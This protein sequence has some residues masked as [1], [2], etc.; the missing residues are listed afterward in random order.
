LEGKGVKNLYKI[1]QI[2]K[3]FNLSKQTL[4]YY[5]KISLLS[6]ETIDEE[7]NYRYYDLEQFARLYLI[8]ELK[9][10]NLS[11]NEIKEYCD[12]KNIKEL[13]QLLKRSK[14]DLEHELEELGAKKENI[15]SCLKKIKLAKSISCK[16][17]FEVR[18]IEERYA[19]FIDFNF[20]IRDINKYTD[21]A[22][23][24]YLHSDVIE[25]N[26]FEPGHIVITM[27][28]ENIMAQNFKIY[29]RIGLLLNK[30]NKGRSNI[31][32]ICQDLYAITYHIGSYDK[33]QN[34]YRELYKFIMENKYT[35]KG[36][37]IEISVT[38]IAY[39]DNTDE[40]VTEIQMPVGCIF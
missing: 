32:T 18:K 22:Y 23:V 5:D 30:P 39:T 25:S 38:D 31:K 4:R 28:K 6:P 37:A 9:K 3:F 40:F 29:N 17:G 11:L 7:T 36:D 20:E 10:M 26:E 15:D 35:I 1:S 8:R 24:S 33:I 34:S 27:S 14:A 13:E 16:H 21:I 12:K 19:Y 2:S